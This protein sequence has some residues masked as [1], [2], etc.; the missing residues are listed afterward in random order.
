MPIEIKRLKQA[1]KASLVKSETSS[2]CTALTDIHVETNTQ[3]YALI[4]VGLRMDPYLI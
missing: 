4:T 3:I 1:I 2:K